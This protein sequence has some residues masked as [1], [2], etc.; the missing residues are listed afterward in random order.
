[1]DR[2]DGTGEGF[3]SVTLFPLSLNRPLL[4]RRVAVGARP[5]GGSGRRGRRFGRVGSVEV[6]LSIALD[7]RI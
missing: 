3:F 5:W 2:R 4:M 1:M 6:S 7:S